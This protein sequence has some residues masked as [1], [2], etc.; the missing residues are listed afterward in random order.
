MEHYVIERLEQM[1]E[2]TK[3]IED[4]KAEYKVVTSY[5]NDIQTL[6]GLTE[7]E[8]SRSQIS[9]PILLL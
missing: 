8:K 6:E 5:L 7:E 4:E 9:H 3:E 1:I 2:T